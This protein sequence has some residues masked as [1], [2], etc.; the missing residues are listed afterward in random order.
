LR[1]ESQLLAQNQSLG[2]SI[3]ATKGR[4][5]LICAGAIRAKKAQDVRFEPDYS[6]KS[7][8]L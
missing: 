4:R 5:F 2:I 6:A 3:V 8:R 1:A 7:S